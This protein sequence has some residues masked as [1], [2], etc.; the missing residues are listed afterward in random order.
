MKHS[1]RLWLMIL[2]IL[3]AGTMI[4]CAEGDDDDDTTTATYRK[5]LVGI[6]FVLTSFNELEIP[7]LI[8]FKEDG[9]VIVMIH[10]KK[11][12]RSFST[13]LPRKVP[14]IVR[15]GVIGNKVKTML[16]PSSFAGSNSFSTQMVIQ[17][18]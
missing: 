16:R 2:A 12:G 14:Q 5:D 17:C 1:R 15:L 8:T 4:A 13:E 10:S 11:E 3:T 18:T 9:S 6:W 7:G